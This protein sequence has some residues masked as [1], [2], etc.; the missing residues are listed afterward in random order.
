MKLGDMETGSVVYVDTNIWYMY[1]RAD[2]A[3]LPEIRQFL[4]RVISGEVA[5][6][7]SLLVLDELIY[8]LLLAQIKD[9]TGQNPLDVL[10]RDTVGAVSTYMAQINTPVKKLIALPNITVVGN[11][12]DDF[13]QMLD[14]MSAFSLLPRDALHLAVMQRLEIAHIASDDKDFERITG[15]MRHWVINP[16]L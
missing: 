7:V 13:Q 14:N 3:Y 8:R 15:I 12:E 5:A 2:P 10:R 6:Y 1:L 9:A 11:T 16:S 4:Q